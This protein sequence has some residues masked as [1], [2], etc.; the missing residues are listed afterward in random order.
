MAS[1]VHCD[2][3]CSLL[4]FTIKVTIICEV[5]MWKKKSKENYFVGIYGEKIMSSILVLLRR[6]FL[7][8]EWEYL[9]LRFSDT[10]YKKWPYAMHFD[11]F[12]RVITLTLIPSTVDI[13]RLK[14]NLE[15][16]N[17]FSQ[18]PASIYEHA[19]HTLYIWAFWMYLKKK[20]RA[21]ELGIREKFEIGFVFSSCWI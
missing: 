10:Y 19:S 21:S 7:R 5:E 3:W 14:L 20:N 13:I 8:R 9:C 18:L 1:R 12:I 17:M 2:L 15:K 11:F 6:T 4:L 16:S